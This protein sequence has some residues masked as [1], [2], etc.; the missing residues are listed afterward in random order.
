ML[1]ILL[2]GLGIFFVIKK[3]S[4]VKNTNTKLET[5]FFSDAV[6]NIDKKISSSHFYQI[7]KSGLGYIIFLELM[8]L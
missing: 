8:E 2:L 3:F 5:E 4:F 6:I 1:I 7:N